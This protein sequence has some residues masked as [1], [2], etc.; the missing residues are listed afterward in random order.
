ML[1]F[2]PLLRLPGYDIHDRTYLDLM[3]LSKN[4]VYCHLMRR[5][6]GLAKVPA[7]PINYMKQWDAEKCQTATASAVR[8]RAAAVRERDGEVAQLRVAR[9]NIMQSD[10]KW[11]FPAPAKAA[12]AER[13]KALVCPQSY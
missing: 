11:D 12:A 7:I 1:D 10:A 5:N 13:M 3:H 6:L 8:A 9:D 2:C 4:T